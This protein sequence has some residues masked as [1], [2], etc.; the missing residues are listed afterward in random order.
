MTLPFDGAISK[1]FNEDIPENVQNAIRNAGKND[2]LAAT[3]PYERRMKRAAYDETMERLQVELVK[4]Q[5]WVHSEGKR[6]AIVFEGR[7]AAGKGGTIK[8]F[9]ENLNPRICK[10][11]ALSKPTE[12][13]RGQ[14]YFQRYIK[15]LPTEGQ[16]TLFDR[17]WYNRGVVEHV[18][19][20]C[21]VKER[22]LF[23]KQV[24]DFE[25]MLVED[26]VIL[27]KLWLN[28]GRAEQLRRMLQREGDKLKQWKLSG[29]DVKGLHKWDAYTQAIAETF[30]KSD[31]K[32]ARWTVIRS[33]DKRRA[34]IAALKRVLNTI[35]YKTKNDRVADRPD[36]QICGGVDKWSVSD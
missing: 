15:E 32:D 10:T 13:E 21:S 7:D 1:F 2:I 16:I 3:Y 35:Q 24:T 34:R 29:I 36:A 9:R 19:G 11:V 25:R 26:D 5:A 4:L 31:H 6:V 22:E 28:V 33:D 12:E 30:E 27:I 23:F 17:S 14:W 18:F 8:R 20:F